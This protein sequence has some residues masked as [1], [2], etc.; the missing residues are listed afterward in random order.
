MGGFITLDLARR[1]P[2]LC[3]ST[4]ATGA[5]PFEGLY[6]FFASHPAIIYAIM[7]TFN[8][9]PDD[10]FWWIAAKQSGIKR[11]D[12]LRE[13]QKTNLK[14]EVIRG[15]YTSILRDFSGWKGWELIR[16]LDKV[17]MVNIAGEKNDDL[18]SSRMIKEV[19]RE[20]GILERLGSR[21]VVVRGAVHPW[22][23]Q[24]PEVFA[25][26]ILRWVKGEE[27]P[28]EFEDL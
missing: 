7:W 16:G 9:L 27:L 8:H 15:V 6:V 22:D 28:A 4:F 23:L 26:G 11:V 25:E 12:A 17:R 1:Y 5:A 24:M 19:W 20:T 2:D 3:L 18:R 14:W 21:V 13:E 10:L